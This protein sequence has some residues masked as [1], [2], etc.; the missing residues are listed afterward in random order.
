MATAISTRG[1]TRFA[2]QQ[3]LA[4]ATQRV[5]VIEEQRL[6]EASLCTAEGERLGLYDIIGASGPVSVFGLALDAGIPI[7]LAFRWLASQTQIGAVVRDV[8]TGRYR[9]WCV[10]PEPEPGTR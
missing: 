2:K 6:Q 3:G 5:A 9:T 8:T 7:S 4:A 10:L 1:L